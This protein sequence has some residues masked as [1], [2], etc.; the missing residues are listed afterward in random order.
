MRFK[1]SLLALTL[2]FCWPAILCLAANEPE[3]VHLVRDSQNHLFIPLTVDGVQSWWGIDTG[4]PFSVIDTSVASRA[5]LSQMFDSN[6]VPLNA[7]VNGRVCP[8]VEVANLS[9]G[10]VNLGA[11]KMAELNL[12]VKPYVKSEEAGPTFEMGGILGIDF[13]LKFNVII[14]FRSQEILIFATDEP[15][16]SEPVEAGYRL[17]PLER[18]HLRRMEVLCRV[19]GFAYPFAI[20][21]GASGTSASTEIAKQNEIRL[22]SRSYSSVSVNG[23][24]SKTLFAP[25]DG[26]QIGDFECGLVEL[27]FTSSTN[28]ARLG[29]GLLGAD[30]LTKYGAIIDVGKNQLY[31]K[32]L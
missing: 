31:L 11:L 18:P 20:D 21:T 26:F 28:P 3:I 30:L 25:I 16:A 15:P 23:G 32:G 13:L 1:H 22:Q 2:L 27:N 29:R 14:K 10:S 19:G 6:R 17:V 24:Q 7:E 12:E 4:F 8:I 5:G 9:A